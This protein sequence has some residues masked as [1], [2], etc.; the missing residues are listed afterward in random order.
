MLRLYI[1]NYT[2]NNNDLHS[3]NSFL[4]SHQIKFA[5]IRAYNEFGTILWPRKE[6]PWV[7]QVPKLRAFPYAYCCIPLQPAL[8][9]VN[10][11]KTL[12]LIEGRDSN[13]PG[14]TSTRT[15]VSVCVGGSW[16][17]GSMLEWGTQQLKAD[18]ESTGLWSVCVMSVNILNN[19]HLFI[20]MLSDT[21]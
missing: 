21:Y 7:L 2:E 4:H 16:K 5:A 9:Y 11:H 13:T 8:A 12:V 14:N 19:E 3:T 17:S 10:W 20:H 18:K 1:I 6:A 15:G